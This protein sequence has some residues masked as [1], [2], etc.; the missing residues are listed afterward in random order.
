M[1]RNDKSGPMGYGPK[2]GRG[3]GLCNGQQDSGNLNMPG[4]GFGRGYGNQ[5]GF[6][7]GMGSRPRAGWGR[8]DQPPTRQEER[9]FLDNQAK[10]LQ[11][12]LDDV[13]QQLSNFETDE[14][15]ES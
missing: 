8:F 13:K 9:S 3:L 11:S 12:R 4:R 14:T 7:R 1:P 15:Q 2:T 5:R 10:V 6:G